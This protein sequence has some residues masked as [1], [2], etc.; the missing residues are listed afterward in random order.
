MNLAMINKEADIFGFLFFEDGATISRCPL[1]N[2]LSSAKNIPVSVLEI[3][4]FQGHLAQGYKKDTTLI[5]NRFL[6][7]MK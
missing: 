5:F 6:K 4:D 2:I 1:L 7:H 3:V